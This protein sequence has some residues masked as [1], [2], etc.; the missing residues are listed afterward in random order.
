MKRSNTYRK[1]FDDDCML[2]VFGTLEPST[3]ERTARFFE[4]WCEWR[5]NRIK[6]NP[7][8]QPYTI[9]ILLYD[10]G[11]KDLFDFQ[12][13]SEEVRFRNQEDYALALLSGLRPY[14]KDYELIN[15]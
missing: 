3:P 6:L 15:V 7:K 12:V 8:T 9:K 4:L 5:P 10:L 14:I 1:L 13:R 11:M 2:E